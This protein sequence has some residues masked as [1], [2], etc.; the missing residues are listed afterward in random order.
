MGSLALGRGR[1]KLPRRIRTRR[2]TSQI[3]TTLS[4]ACTP[5]GDCLRATSH[6]PHASSSA[7]LARC[8]RVQGA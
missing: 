1:C 2:S 8:V 4:A 7:L 5:C 3:Q 6:A